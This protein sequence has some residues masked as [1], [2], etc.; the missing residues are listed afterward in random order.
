MSAK[1]RTSVS[2][3][4]ERLRGERAQHWLTADR[5]RFYSVGGMICFAL[6]VSIY[7]VRVMWTSH[8]YLSP[9]ALDFVPF[10]S[11]SHLAMLGHAVDAYNFE[12]LRKVETAALSHPVGMLLWLYPPSFLLIVC[13]FALVPWNIGATLF[14]G[15]TYLMFIKAV[16]FIVRRKETMMVAAAFP[17]AILVA[18]AGQNGLLTASLVAFGLVLLP[19]RPV[20]AGVCFGILCVKPQLAVL[21]PFALLCARSWRSLGALVVTALAMLAIAMALFGVD[22]LWAF[23]HSMGTVAR[24]VEASRAAMYRMP[25]A[26][27][28]IKMMH[29]PT[30]LANAAQAVSAV[31]AATAVWY[32]WS[33]DASHAL[34]AATLVCA[35]LMVSPYLYDYDL[36]WLGV[37]IAWYV[38]HAMEHGW[39]PWQREWLIVLWLMPFAGVL[40]VGHLHFQ[41]MPLI[42]AM[43][44]AMV[45]RRIALERRAARSM[46]A[47]ASHRSAGVHPA[48]IQI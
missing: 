18:L 44:L 7:L 6:L 32:A 38:K 19:R 13:P 25:S 12:V 45:V 21:L 20:L 16:H 2:T 23:L 35:S 41:F 42:I 4:V 39:R 27:S 28:F 9:L 43:T 47:L 30:M 11:A 17:G 10:W 36:A 48:G 8:E 15:V 33:R 34:R 31:S 26:Y 37:F 3:F 46:E 24:Y 14:F 40:I 5:L 29:G 22:T 1:V